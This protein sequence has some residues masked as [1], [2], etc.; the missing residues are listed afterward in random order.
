MKT[1]IRPRSRSI[2]DTLVHSPTRPPAHRWTRVAHGIYVDGAPSGLD[3]LRALSLIL[4]ARAAYTHLTAAQLLGWWRPGPVERVH[5]V[6]VASRKGDSVPQR[7]GIRVARL[8]EWPAARLVRGVRVVDAA[9][10]MLAASRDLGVL[11]LVQL[12]DSAL[13]LDHCSV[14]DLVT[15]ASGRRAGSVQ[16]RRVIPLLDR[17]SE[18]PWESVLRVLHLAAG[19]SVEPQKEFFDEHGRFVARADLWLTGTRRV[20]EFDGADHRTRDGHRRDLCRERG[21]IGIGVE[22]CGYTPPE[23]L[24]GGRDI[25]ASADRVLGRP[26]DSD[27]LARWN[28]LVDDS[29]WGVGGRARV[30]RRWKSVG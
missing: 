28:A 15:A 13:R 19:I 23:V 2:S 12:G 6:F 21:L 9:E 20:H 27:R 10:V 1:G 5:P 14:D 25:I 16:L 8:A 22:R 17:R 29:L 26:W 30:R 4:P 7:S 11:D 3:E 18:S 24:S